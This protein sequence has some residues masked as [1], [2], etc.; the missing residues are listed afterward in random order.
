MLKGSNCDRKS[1][2]SEILTEPL[3]PRG[4]RKPNFKQFKLFLTSQIYFEPFKSPKIFKIFTKTNLH[5][6]ST[7]H[8][9]FI[10]TTCLFIVLS[11]KE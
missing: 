2:F 7:R 9:F 11:Q 3:N 4:A 6:C 1:Q 5:F 8:A 10:I